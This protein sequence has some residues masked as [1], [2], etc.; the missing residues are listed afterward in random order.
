M[1]SYWLCKELN[2]IIKNAHNRGINFP[3]TISESAA[4][5]ALGFELN[6]GSGGDARNPQTNDILDN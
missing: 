5:Y 6:R 2:A 1:R 3:E 4:C